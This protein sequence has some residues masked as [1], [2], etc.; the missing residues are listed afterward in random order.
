[1]NNSTPAKAKAKGKAKSKSLAFEKN[2]QN[3]RKTPVAVSLLSTVEGL[4]WCLGKFSILDFKNK[5][6]CKKI[7]TEVGDF[8]KHISKIEIFEVDLV[9][10][11]LFKKEWFILDFSENPEIIIF[12]RNLIKMTLNSVLNK[13][14]FLKSWTQIS[15]IVVN[16]L[17]EFSMSKFDRYDIRKTTLRTGGEDEQNTLE[18]S[19][20]DRFLLSTDEIRL[21]CKNL[22]RTTE[23]GAYIAE[24]DY[25]FMVR[26]L[27]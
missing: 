10:S 17:V 3:E 9:L 15:T 12:H 4:Q 16:L 20:E 25:D 7:L 6:E 14:G 19:G 23:E 1:M 22:L 5:Y 8:L 24:E 11:K 13:N 2:T 27:I 26:M 21:R 18:T